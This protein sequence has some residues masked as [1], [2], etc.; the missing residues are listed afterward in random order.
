MYDGRHLVHVGDVVV[1]TFNYRLGM[2]A[3]VGMAVNLYC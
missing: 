3:S 2:S 1:V